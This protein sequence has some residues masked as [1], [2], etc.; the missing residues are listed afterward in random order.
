VAEAAVEE[1]VDVL[2]RSPDLTARDARFADVMLHRAEK[3]AGNEESGR[4]P[5]T[6]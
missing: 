6:K 2:A 4:E 1:P 5:R 3:R